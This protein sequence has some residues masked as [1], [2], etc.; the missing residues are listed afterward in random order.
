L[1]APPLPTSILFPYTT[2]FRSSRPP[3]D[4]P[5]RSLQGVRSPQLLPRFP[6]ELEDREALLQILLH[7]LRQFRSPPGIG[8]D[9]F[10]QFGSGV[11]HVHC[12]PN[13]PDGLAH[14]GPHFHLGDIGLG[15]LSQVELAALPKH[16]WEQG[17]TRLPEASVV[18]ADYQMDA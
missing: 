8:F 1:P 10:R 12:V 17:S 2:L 5:I 7:P 14:L 9:G 11:L 15:I 6:R 13:V 16:R 4:L 3:L 18:V